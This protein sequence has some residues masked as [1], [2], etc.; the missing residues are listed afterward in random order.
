MNFTYK[1][2]PWNITFAPGAVSN[3]RGMVEGLGFSKALILSTSG[4]SQNAQIVA[5]HLGEL[6]VGHFDQA[7]M[8]VPIETVKE[9]SNLAKRLGADCTVSIGGGSTTGLGKALALR[10]NLPNIAIPTT[11]AGS[12]MTNIWGITEKGKKVTGRD[13]IVVPNLVIYDPELTL[14]L[15]PSVVGPSGLNALAQAV[16]NVATDAPNT[17]VSLMALEAIKDIAEN[18]P[19]IISEPENLDARSKVLYGSSMAGA[20]LGTGTTSLHHKLCHTFG[21][22]FKT[23]HAETHAILLPHSVAYNA[24]ATA[25]GS[26]AVADAMGV[27]DAAIGIRDL[28]L[29]VGAPT[30]L[31][32]I[33]ISEQ[34]IGKAVEIVLGMDFHNPE[35]ITETR[36]RHMMENAYH[37]REPTIDQA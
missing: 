22:A 2:L 14:S 19:A 31:K 33:G 13:D 9:A 37:G 34:D 25:D 4:Q 1:P 11:Y 36:L 12:E 6:I 5:S 23:P 20:S 18:L 30:A 24:K 3:I 27:T 16:V 29:K 32:D 8:H 28:A 15:P 10:K 21:G 26:Q 35:P 7:K 17:M